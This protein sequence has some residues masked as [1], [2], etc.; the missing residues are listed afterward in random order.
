MTELTLEQKVDVIMDVAM[1]AKVRQQLEDRLT[2]AAHNAEMALSQI[3]SHEKI[4]E[5][6]YKNI[7]GKLDTA[8]SNQAANNL[9]VTAQIEKVFASLTGTNKTSWIGLGAWIGTMGVG[10]VL[11]ILY[12]LK[13]VAN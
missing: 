11:G 2:Q 13:Q 8:I 9:A 1:N 12:T 3:N 4:C 5:L 10:T 6:R 7:E